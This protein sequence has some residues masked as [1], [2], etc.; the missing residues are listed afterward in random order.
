MA[1]ALNILVQPSTRAYTLSR[2]CGWHRECSS[3]VAMRKLLWITLAA[4]WGACEQAPTVPQGGPL[5]IDLTQVTLQPTEDQ[6]FCQYVAPDGEERWLDRFTVDLGAGSHHLIVFRRTDPKQAGSYGPMPCDQLDLPD[7]IDGMLPGA[8]SAHSDLTLP[9]GV[10]MRLG[11]EHGLFFQFHF[12]NAT[13]APLE[14]RVHWAAETV[15][16]AQ[17][18]TQAALLFYSQWELKVPPGQ[19]VQS[20]FCN[21]PRDLSLL[22]ATGHMH[23]HGLSF[24]ASAGDQPIFH[25]DDWDAPG[26]ARFQP[27]LPLRAG[28]PLRWSCE[29]D[30]DTGAELDFGPSAS[31]NE[32]CILAGIFYP[33]DGQTDFGC[34]K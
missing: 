33:S 3:T 11:P 34:Q 22:M 25:T 24:D 16:P 4:L 13:Q 32:M 8:Q 31:L 20:D 23:R 12:I 21:A 30:N 7:G 15:E 10:A 17:V 5:S 28:T 1:H 19:S 29:Y 9:D 18:K 26:G 27:P 6:V 2:G 14:T